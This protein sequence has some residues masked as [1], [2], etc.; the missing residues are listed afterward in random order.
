MGKIDWEKAKE[1]IDLSDENY[2]ILW[3]IIKH[4]VEEYHEE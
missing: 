4:Y 3:A 1:N 2:K